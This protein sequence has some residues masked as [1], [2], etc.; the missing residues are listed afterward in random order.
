MW[1]RDAVVCGCWA[2]GLDRGRFK[3]CYIFPVRPRL[4]EH[5]QEVKKTGNFGIPIGII[6]KEASAFFLG[7]AI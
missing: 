5:N 1:A 4:S 3:E 7:Q 6:D 2:A